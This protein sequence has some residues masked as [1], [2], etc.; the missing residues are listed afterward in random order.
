ML[1]AVK[2]GEEKRSSSALLNRTR[3]DPKRR[4]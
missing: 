2:E 1:E 3:E 4:D